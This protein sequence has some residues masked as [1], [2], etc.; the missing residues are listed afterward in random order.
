M[1]LS[2]AF[3]F[4]PFFLLRNVFCAL[5]NSPQHGCL[6][7]KGGKDHTSRFQKPSLSDAEPHAVSGGGGHKQAS[8]PK[9][10]A[11]IAC[12]SCVQEGREGRE[13]TGEKEEKGA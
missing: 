7:K 4:S 3:F 8:N 10:S 11:L 9:W 1:L 12:G 6:N 2:L 13:G 5:M